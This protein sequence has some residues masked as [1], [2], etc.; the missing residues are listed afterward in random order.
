MCHVAL[1]AWLAPIPRERRTR[2]E[3]ENNA[4]KAGYVLFAG[5]VAACVQTSAAS[6]RTGEAA[7]SMTAAS[8]GGG[9]AGHQ[10]GRLRNGHLRQQVAALGLQ[11]LSGR[12]HGRQEALLT[13]ISCCIRK[14]SRLFN[15]HRAYAQLF[16]L[17]G[18]DGTRCSR[19]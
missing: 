5:C 8:A 17:T 9:V 13:L 7:N 4:D 1:A 11:L 16:R 19:R 14:K 15:Q 2:D 10:R 12:Q 3:H 18:T 6:P